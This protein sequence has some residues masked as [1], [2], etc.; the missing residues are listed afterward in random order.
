MYQLMRR[1]MPAK[2]FKGV[3]MAYAATRVAER[4]ARKNRTLRRA[5]SLVNT[6]TWAVPLGMMAWR[7]FGPRE[8][9]PAPAAG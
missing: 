3:A 5:L 7:H 1:A 4:V 2:G 8:A 9:E 6:A